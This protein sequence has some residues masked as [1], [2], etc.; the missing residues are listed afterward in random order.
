MYEDEPGA[1]IGV[2]IYGIEV[3]KMVGETGPGF[4]LFARTQDGELREFAR[5]ASQGT[6]IVSMGPRQIALCMYGNQAD[7]H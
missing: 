6:T 1:E 5:F 7:R 3:R 2:L 4:Q